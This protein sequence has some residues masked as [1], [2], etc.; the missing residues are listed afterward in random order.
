MFGN[1]SVYQRLIQRRLCQE[2][3]LPDA[4]LVAIINAT[5]DLLKDYQSFRGFKSPFLN[6]IIEEFSPFNMFQDQKSDEISSAKI[7]RI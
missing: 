4:M 2:S 7:S 1:V 3:L 5:D 6:Q